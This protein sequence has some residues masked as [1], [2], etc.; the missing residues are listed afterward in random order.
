MFHH[1]LGSLPGQTAEVI[2][3]TTQTL[4]RGGWAG[5]VAVL[6]AAIAVLFYRRESEREKMHSEM[7]ELQ[8][9]FQKELL[10]L[11]EVQTAII[12]KQAVLTEKVETLLIRVTSRLERTE[13]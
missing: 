2:A 13:D 6:C 4:E 3:S 5:V 12:T 7:Q 9:G 11:V 8:H 1:L 10:R